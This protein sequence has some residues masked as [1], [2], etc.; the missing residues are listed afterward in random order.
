MNAERLTKRLSSLVASTEASKLKNIYT[1]LF[2][3]SIWY[4]AYQNIY[5]NRGA[6]TKGVGSDTIDQFD[7]DR[8]DKIILSL[9]NKTYN[10]TPVRR[11]LIPKSNGK[12]RPLGIPN[13]TDKLVQEACRII[14]EAIY[15]NKF[16]D[17]SHGFR[18]NRSCH[19]ALREIYNWNSINWFIE[20]DI[21]G[22]FD[23]INHEILIDILEQRIDNSNFIELIKKFLKAGYIENWKYNNTYSGTPQGGI[24]SPILANIYLNELDNYINQL[25]IKIN[26]NNDIYNDR[27]TINPEYKK[28]QNR[29]YC[30]SNQLDKIN[31]YISEC[32][33][34]ISKYNKVANNKCHELMTECLNLRGSGTEIKSYNIIYNN[35]NIV[36]SITSI[37][38]EDLKLLTKYKF[39][40]KKVKEFKTE[41]KTLSKD[42]LSTKYLNIEDRNYRKLSYVRYADD[43]VC[44]FIGKR[45]EAKLIK[46][47]IQTFLK[48]KLK[49][50]LS[51]NKTK[52]KHSKEGILF[53]GYEILY[54]KFNNENV[55]VTNNIDNSFKKRR[56]RVKPVFK[57]P[58]QKAI[59][60]V[61]NK[62]YGDYVNNIFDHRSYLINFD[63]YEIINQYNSELRG[64]INYYK[65]A[66]NNKA[67]IG[68][69]QYIVHYSLLKTFGAKYKCSI[70]QLFKNNII[71]VDENKYWYI[72]DNDQ[73]IKVFKIKDVKTKK[74]FEYNPTDYINDNS[75]IKRL[76]IRNSAVAKLIADECETC[77]SKKADGVKIHLHHLNKIKNIPNTDPIY[78][79]VQKARSRKTIA[80]C[81]D[82]HKKLHGK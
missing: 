78:K 39:Y 16:N 36:E 71:K 60:F 73:L 25:I 44:G 49:L 46:D 10:P 61:K 26:E 53:L 58:T 27:K 62:G 5:S 11:V 81:I 18:P 65:F 13:G 1:L 6:F 38:Y 54:L 47:K 52:I 67:I 55:T 15:E 63:K 37:D 32:E 31:N 12:T 30:V 41:F 34:I 8:I 69:V 72:D 24:I 48:E 7:K 79:K 23:N 22:C 21:K 51:E 40:I 45:E 50:D 77:G 76:D 43:F 56:N 68:R 74:I 9:K 42:L 14:L 59:E 70:A 80:V 28:I 17:S 66:I 29:K 4:I 33:T 19:S 57:V 75:F 20:F 82:C 3:E 35:L 2:E 64:L